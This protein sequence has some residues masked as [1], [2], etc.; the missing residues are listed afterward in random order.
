MLSLILGKAGSGKTSEIIRQIRTNVEN[1][2]GR[3][4]YIVPEQYSFEAERELCGACPDSASL[5]AEV[6][7]F[8]G[9]ARE[10]SRI[11]GGAERY[12]DDGGKLLCMALTT[13]LLSK[14]GQL[15]TFG[16]AAGKSETQDVLVSAMDELSASGITEEKL[17]SAAAQVEGVLRDKLLDLALIRET[18]DETVR[19]S[20][21]FAGDRLEKTAENIRRAENTL[22]SDVYIDGFSDFTAGELGVIEALM[23]NG[24]NITVCLTTDSL[25]TDCE[26]F[27]IPAATGRRLYKIAKEHGIDTS[28]PELSP[29]ESKSDAIRLFSEEM[30]SYREK[31]ICKDSDAIT[32]RLCSSPAAECETAAAECLKLVRET[33]CRWRDIA[34]AVRSF[35]EYRTV[36]KSI[37]DYYSVPLF[38]A[39]RRDITSEPLPMLIAC[40]YEIVRNGW[41]VDDVISYMRTG[42]T[43]LTVEECDL[44]EN[45]IFKWQIDERSWHRCGRWNQNPDGYKGQPEGEAAER[46]ATVNRAAKKLAAPLLRFASNGRA[47]Q[48]AAE[49][50]ENL[51]GFMQDLQLD[52]AVEKAGALH[53]DNGETEKVWNICVTALEQCRAVLAD[54]EI[55]MTEF[56][57]LFIRMLSKYSVSTIPYSLDRVSAGDFNRMRRR[58]IRH[59]IVLGAD[60]SRLPKPASEEGV[61]TPEEKER[62]L[63]ADIAFNAGE[64]ELWREFSLIYNCLSLPSET[65]S[66]SCSATDS[67][68]ARVMP[69]FVMAQAKRLFGKEIETGDVRRARLS[70]ELPAMD[71]AVLAGELRCPEAMAAEAYYSSRCPEKLKQLKSTGGS[72]RGTLSESSVEGLYGANIKL[73]ASRS[74]S[75]SNCPYGYFCNYGLKAEPY[76]PADFNPAEIGSFMHR[77]FERTSAEV[78]SLGGFRTVPEEKLLEISDRHIEDFIKEAL[79][80]FEEKSDRFKYLFNRLRGDVHAVLLDA[81]EE[82]KQSE[83]EP[84]DFELDIGSSGMMPKLS[85]GDGSSEI[86]MSG[87]ADRVDGWEHDGKLYLRVVDYKTGKKA[88]KLEDVYYGLN[89]QMLLYLMALESS[90]TNRYGKSVQGAGIVYFPARD[91]VVSADNSSEEEVNKKRKEQKKR[92]GLVLDDASV[93]S[94]WDTSGD[95]SFSPVKKGKWRVGTVADEE[96]MGSLSDFVKKKLKTMG[97]DIR[98]GIISADPI[99]IN[100]HENAC[101]HC[102]YAEACGFAD[103]ERGEHIR[104]R[105]K[106]ESGEVWDRIRQENENE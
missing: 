36:L 9:L 67:D 20:G 43:G 37:F 33:G 64:D 71:L 88:F 77:I 34:I 83:F 18:Y 51:A 5:Y 2:R 85:L 95:G 38:I 78:V 16:Y 63:D 60:D 24:S 68:G 80:G 87:I 13:D 72:G 21:A 15:K 17:R 89:M 106:L 97:E 22:F 105:D 86:I 75:F 65:L 58:S 81:A 99:Y 42:L 8:T 100:E 50:C 40:A 49:H 35:E 82:L 55:S 91:S 48:K 84:L 98:H 104:R 57:R 25:D 46:L 28:F 101:E 47:L 6:F 32:L 92:S 62:L 4:I 59:L 79:G 39:E 12:L 3:S 14:T 70:A 1:R 26:A 30:F 76:K 27:F 19:L 56:G 10:I 45:Y 44:V 23:D 66:M 54:T 61:F 94:A 31:A 53:D 90:G 29:N 41:Q 11:Y 74:D 73:T 102:E 103:G 69:S 7:S 52:I 96:Q 93:I